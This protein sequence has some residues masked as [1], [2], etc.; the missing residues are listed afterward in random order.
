MKEFKI[1]DCWISIIL[2]PAFV[3]FGFITMNDKS[4]NG[5]FIVGGWQVVSMIVHTLNHWFTKR[6]EQRA[7]YHKL[8]LILAAIIAV[9][10]GFTYAFEVFFIV[11][12]IIMFLLLIA[13]PV[14]AIYYTYVCYEETY[15]RMKRPMDFLK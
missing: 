12:A 6:G 10:I 4:F 3:I 2:I 5:Y 1:I 14:M 15:I 13:S 7:Y 8:V 11:L 9:L